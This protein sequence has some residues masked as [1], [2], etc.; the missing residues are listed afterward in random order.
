MGS[1]HEIER[2]KIDIAIFYTVTGLLIEILGASAVDHFSFFS[3]IESC[4]D[5]NE[6]AFF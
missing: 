1:S 5:G 2:G 4:P 6:T 3:E